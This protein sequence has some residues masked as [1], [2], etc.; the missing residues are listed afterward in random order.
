MKKKNLDKLLTA[1]ATCFS[2]SAIC[3]SVVAIFAGVMTIRQQKEDDR[4]TVIVELSA[5]EK[6]TLT[7][8]E[9]ICRNGEIV[10][11][12]LSFNWPQTRNVRL[13]V[14]TLPLIFNQDAY[15]RLKLLLKGG[16]TLWLDDNGNCWLGVNLGDTLRYA[17]TGIV[18]AQRFCSDDFIIDMPYLELL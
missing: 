5:P 17:S 13:R 18:R 11:L 16:E 8:A 6:Q 12:K 14:P 9:E 10:H 2:A 3:L 1:S 15:G 4:Q 7:D